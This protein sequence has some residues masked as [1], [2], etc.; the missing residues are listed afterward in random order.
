MTSTEAP[1]RFDR[2]GYF[3]NT[4]CYGNLRVPLGDS[5]TK[6][7][8]I[9][10]YEEQYSAPT[11]PH[12]LYDAQARF[13]DFGGS[14][15]A[16]VPTAE[17]LHNTVHVIADINASLQDVELKAR[18]MNRREH[19][20]IGIFGSYAVGSDYFISAGLTRPLAIHRVKKRQMGVTVRDRRFWHLLGFKK[21]VSDFRHILDKSLEYFLKT[22]IIPD[23]LGFAPKGKLSSLTWEAIPYKSKNLLVTMGSGEVKI[24]DCESDPEFHSIHAKRNVVKVRTLAM[25]AGTMALDLSLRIVEKLHDIRMKLLKAPRVLPEEQEQ[26]YRGF[27]T[28]IDILE[29]SGTA[30]RVAGGFALN[31]YTGE[32]YSPQRINGKLRD[33]D[34]LILSDDAQIVQELQKKI[35]DSKVRSKTGFPEVKLDFLS[36]VYAQDQATGRRFPSYQGHSVINGEGRILWKYGDQ[37]IDIDTELRAENRLHMAE[38][39]FS[40][41]S[42]EIL[43]FTAICRNGELGWTDQNY[44]ARLEKAG[45]KVFFSEKFADYYIDLHRKYPKS[46]RNFCFKDALDFWLGGKIRGS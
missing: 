36:S 35:D 44:S 15:V 17:R 1:V 8:A 22:G 43:L 16:F 25:V 2:K 12:P 19:D 4:S 20:L 7:Q 21:T 24:I 9:S 45:K 32:N 40:A 27:A 10:Y 38:R 30:Y 26:F 31:A 42:P 11:N 5:F 18:A 37:T 33:I 3:D 28:V 41:L 46:I 23:V 13:L 39:E 29:N 6:K 14:S 34:I